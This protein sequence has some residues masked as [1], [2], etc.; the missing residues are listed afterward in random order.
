MGN[1]TSLHHDAFSRAYCLAQ[2][3][4]LEVIYIDATEP[5]IAAERQSHTEPALAVAKPVTVIV[6]TRV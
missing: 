2:T 1:P 3:R 5:V 4:C 6:G